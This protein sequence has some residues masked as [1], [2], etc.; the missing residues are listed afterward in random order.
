MAMFS[1]SQRL[2]LQP[3]GI[4]VVDLRT[5]AVAT[6]LIANQKVLT[7]IHLPRGSI[8]EPA[9][10]TVEGAM[11]NEKMADVGTPA[12][13]WADEVVKDLLK[14]TPPMT[15]WKGAQARL[16]RIGTCFPHGMLDGTM[17]KMTG[18]DIVEQ[19]VKK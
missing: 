13:Q 14:K 7:T 10:E 19:M 15:I 16:G 6:N 1:D 17:K 9:K 3:F 5:G 18:L 2:E 12:Q 11:R 4:T 8:Y